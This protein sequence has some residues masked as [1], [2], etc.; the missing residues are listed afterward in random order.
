MS[1]ADL[2]FYA[3]LEEIVEEESRARYGDDAVPTDHHPR[4]LD[5]RA[6]PA[7]AP[8][9]ARSNA[10]DILATPIAEASA[11]STSAHLGWLSARPPTAATATSQP[12]RTLAPTQPSPSLSAT[13]SHAVSS[14]IRTAS[15]RVDRLQG[16]QQPS[17][18]LFTTPNQTRDADAPTSNSLTQSGPADNDS[19]EAMDMDDQLGQAQSAHDDAI[20]AANIG[21]PPNAPLLASLP[22]HDSPTVAS[23]PRPRLPD[24]D[25]P[26]AHSCRAHATLA[27]PTS[28][29]RAPVH[30]P[31]PLPAHLRNALA[32]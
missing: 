20:A 6:A 13:T 30:P 10:F 27:D 1:D 28:F 32:A 7:I 25:R 18:S 19:D 4:I 31:T 5:S 23:P 12:L 15:G 22:H 9:A 29:V 3:Q 2:A 16:W 11:P 14:S 21:Q 24:P 17:P 26:P 8:T